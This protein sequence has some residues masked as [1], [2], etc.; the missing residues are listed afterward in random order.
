MKKLNPAEP[1][2][3]VHEDYTEITPSNTLR[4]RA[5]VRSHKG[6]AETFDM[7]ARA[8]KALE[9]LAPNFNEWMLSEVKRLSEHFEVFDASVKDADDYKSFF[10]VAHD[11][12][13]QAMQFGYPIAGHLAS[14]L[15]DVL[16]NRS[17]VPVPPVILRRYVEAISSIVRSGVKDEANATALELARQLGRIVAE[18]RKESAP[19][20]P[21]PVDAANVTSA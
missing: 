2:R 10:M 20:V 4:A 9:A 16:Q 15:C 18:Y 21:A 6:Q 5:L 3:T 1:Q 13:G 8:E 7:I 12:R 17:S 19:D 14:G 11:V